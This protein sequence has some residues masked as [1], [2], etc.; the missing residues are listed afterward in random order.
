MVNLLGSFG[1]IGGDL[2]H[3]FSMVGQSIESIPKF[4]VSHPVES[5]IAIGGTVAV[6]AAVFFTGGIDAAAAPAEESAVLGASVG[7]DALIGSIDA[8]GAAGIDGGAAAAEDAG[9]GIAETTGSAA[10]TLGSAASKYILGP[11]GTGLRYGL[12]IAIAGGFINYGLTEASEGLSNVE[13]AITGQQ[14]S[15]PYPGSPLS[16][17]F[18]L[19]GMS[20][21]QSSQPVSTTPSSSLSNILNS[22]L[23]E[24]GLIIAGL[25]VLY[26]ILKRR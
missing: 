18:G 3:G 15:I 14:V 19:G 21:S 24:V 6:G 16:G 22:P 7:S 9:A 5:A 26:E 13:S 11:I 1:S 12:P 10:R 8:T 23:V 17:L 20:S 4:V 2:M 25:F